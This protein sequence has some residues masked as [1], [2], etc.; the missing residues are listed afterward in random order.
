MLAGIAYAVLRGTRPIRLAGVLGQAENRFRSA[1]A[2]MLVATEYFLALIFAWTALL[3]ITHPG[4][5]SP[6]VGGVLALTLVFLVAT[7]LF[8]VRLGQGGMRAP[9]SSQAGVLSEGGRPVGD[10]TQ[11]R[12]WKGG[13]LYFN[14]EDPAIFVEKRFG[15]GYTLNF[16]RPASWIMLG[17]VLLVPLVIGFIVKWGSR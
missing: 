4:P 14:S 2:G 6:P 12:Y 7:I 9:G 5:G 3:P 17:A 15:I 1:V 8:V 11:D 16:A 10:R 13:L